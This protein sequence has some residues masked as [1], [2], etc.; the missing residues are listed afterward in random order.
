MDYKYCVVLERINEDKVR[1]TFAPRKD[2]SLLKNT[3]MCKVFFSDNRGL[4]DI[5]YEFKSKIPPYSI[6][7]FDTGICLEYD[8]QKLK[9]VYPFFVKYMV[10]IGH[11]N[12]GLRIYC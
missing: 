11:V 3:Q 2:Y 5:I 12:D 1:F 9:E 6:G 7:G 8:L 10:A 4:D